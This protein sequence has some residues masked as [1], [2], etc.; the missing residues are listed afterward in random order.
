MTTATIRNICSAV[1]K[2][3]PKGVN[4][5]AGP[6]RRFMSPHP[7]PGL[8]SAEGSTK[9]GIPAAHCRIKHAWGGKIATCGGDLFCHELCQGR[10]RTGGP[11]FLIWTDQHESPRGLF[12]RRIPR[13]LCKE[14]MGSHQA[15]LSIQNTCTISPRATATPSHEAGSFAVESAGHRGGGQEKVQT[16]GRWPK[17]DRYGRGWDAAQ[18]ASKHRGSTGNPGERHGEQSP[19]PVPTRPPDGRTGEW[20]GTAPGIPYRSPPCSRPRSATVAGIAA[21]AASRARRLRRTA[22]SGSM[23]STA[24]RNSSTGRRSVAVAASTPA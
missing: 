14:P 7:G 15:P 11:S 2:A 12:A 20:W 22:G 24:V 23:T 17:Q 13:D 5:R 8:A 19:A 6:V 16:A 18:V 1:E 4:G 10:W 3:A 21:T 9:Q